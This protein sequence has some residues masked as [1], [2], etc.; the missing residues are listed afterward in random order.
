MKISYSILV[1]NE[2]NTLE[3]LLEFLVKY[4]QPQDEIVILDD[5]STEE[6]TKA[7]LDYYSSAEGV[8]L[9]QRNL[10]KDF[11][12]QKNYLKS[13]CTGDYSFNLDA[14]EIVSHWF[15]K[16]IHE[17]L[18]GNEVDLIFVPR[19]NTVDG[20]TKEHCKMYGYKMNEKGWINYPD[21][22]GHIFRNRPNIRWEKPVHEQLT[23]FQTYA[24]LPMEQKYSIVHPKTIERQVEQNRFYNEEISMG[25][26]LGSSEEIK[27]KDKFKPISLEYFLS[28]E[29][30]SGGPSKVILNRYDKLKTVKDVVEFYSDKDNIKLVEK[31][32]KPNNWQ[33]FNCMLAEFRHNVADHHQLGWE[34]MTKEYYE[35]LDLMTDEEIEVFNKINPVE[36]DN[37]LMKHGYHRG[38]AMIG[39]LIAGK[40]YI[41]LY[42]EKEKI[43]NIP[44]KNDSKIRINN[45]MYN[46]R[47]LNE[48]NNLDKNEYCLTQSSILALM[49]LRQNN[50]VDI[51]IS[52]KLRS[53]LGIGDQ[54]VKRGNVE[55][56]SPNYDKFM[57]NGANSDDDIIQNHTFEFEGYKFLEPRF[58]FSRK[59]KNDEKNINDWKG[60]K[61]F[62]E[63]ESYKG[64]PFSEL[65]YEKWGFEYL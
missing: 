61:R 22:Q 16:D 1:H 9:E 26:N 12:S 49:G 52:S 21:W 27:K 35:S 40:P 2:T 47:C 36:F 59:N 15:L 41:P 56:F 43:Y 18:E 42:M 8:I 13:M 29:V 23:G 28:M 33:Y 44:W 37:G 24:H 10:L 17:I 30:A 25:M 63:M 32:L 19:I 31:E 4:K 64:Y 48:L 60:I 5:Y 39:R 53:Q 62:Y 50:D 46:I 7:I 11:A 34:N 51:I 55:I 54:Y 20:I 58:Y 65:E 57:I 6:Q 14:D 45:P 3:K 38:Y